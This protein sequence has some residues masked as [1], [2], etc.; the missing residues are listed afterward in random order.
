VAAPYFS[1][2]G[3]MIPCMLLLGKKHDHAEIKILEFF[4]EFGVLL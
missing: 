1:S 3:V 4:Q 2:A